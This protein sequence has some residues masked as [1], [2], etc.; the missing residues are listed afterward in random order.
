VTMIFLVCV[1]PLE[2]YR[3]VGDDMG[4]ALAFISVVIIVPPAI[5]FYFKVWG[6]KG[7]IDDED[8]F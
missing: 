2:V 5:W 8:T 7:V 6:N 3:A 4:L 1:V